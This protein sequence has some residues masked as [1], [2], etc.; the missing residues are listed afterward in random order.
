MQ[1]MLRKVPMGTGVRQG[2]AVSPL[3]YSLFTAWFL[4]ELEA[5]TSASWV[6]QLVTCFADD[7]H[8]AMGNRAAAPT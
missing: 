1:H 4:S 5:R 7:T 6:Q 2:C 8:L 3:L